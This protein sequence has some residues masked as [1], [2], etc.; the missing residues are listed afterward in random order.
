LYFAHWHVGKAQ[1]DD[2]GRFLGIDLM[3]EERNVSFG[4][5]F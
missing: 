5:T 1:Q 2:S 4:T 3:R